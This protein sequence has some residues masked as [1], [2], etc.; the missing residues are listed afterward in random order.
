MS[1]S[2][3]GF[4][5]NYFSYISTSYD[6]GSCE[7]PQTVQESQS[8]FSLPYS[9]Y[10]WQ[11]YLFKCNICYMEVI[12]LQPQGGTCF[13]S[14]FN[15]S[16]FS[17]ATGIKYN[18]FCSTY[19]YNCGFVNNQCICT[20]EPGTLFYDTLNSENLIFFQIDNNLNIIPIKEDD[21]MRMLGVLVN[22]IGCEFKALDPFSKV[23]DEI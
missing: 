16:L 14:Y 6:F 15:Q 3:R 17:I 11:S 5:S 21:T 22:I 9:S 4:F 12:T 19:S 2:V 7:T 18:S 20:Q 1:Y 13:Y 10:Y 8:Y 23:V